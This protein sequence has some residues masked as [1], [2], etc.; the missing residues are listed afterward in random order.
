MARRPAAIKKT[1]KPKV[2]KLGKKAVASLNIKYHGNE[3][4]INDIR[5]RDWTECYTWY[6]YN[7]DSSQAK[8]FLIDFLEV[9]DKAKA[10]IVSNIDDKTVYGYASTICWIA[11]LMSNGYTMSAERKEFFDRKL[12]NLI[13]KHNQRI[14]EKKD[15]S[16]DKAQRVALTEAKLYEKR[17]D[18]IEFFEENFRTKNYVNPYEYLSNG[19]VPKPII[20]NIYNH[21][22]PLLV[23]LEELMAP[24]KKDAQI[25]EYYAK[26]KVSQIKADLA[27]ARLILDDCERFL[28]NKKAERKPRK[29]KVIPITDKLKDFNYQTADLTLK[30]TSFNPLKI[31][32]AKE[33]WTY[34]TKYNIITVYRT[35][36][37]FDVKGTTIL[38]INMETSFSK[39]VG[40]KAA[41]D[42]IV[43]V[44][45]TGKVGLRTLMNE[46]N[47]P[48]QEVK[49]RIGMNSILLRYTT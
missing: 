34:N 6:N 24:G 30:L 32:E 45:N 14:D 10:K 23:E 42:S 29:K 40:S 37:N 15:N 33:I 48:L 38:N 4:S 20:Q 44:L 27:Y 19:E 5:R 39:R 9:V 1:T 35:D 31:F 7:C 43:K 13:D 8:D 41:S 22:K 49:G 17:L 26:F 18:V 2:I 12:S 16:D 11:R 28:Q 3:P 46:L 25:L 36:T 21:Y 47:G